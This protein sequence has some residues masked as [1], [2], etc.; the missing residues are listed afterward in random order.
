MS[1]MKNA[2]LAA[3]P[4]RFPT[5]RLVL[6]ILIVILAVLTS[7]SGAQETDPHP[8][9]LPGTMYSLGRFTD[10]GVVLSDFTHTA[11]RFRMPIGNDGNEDLGEDL[12]LLQI[13]VWPESGYPKISFNRE[14]P[15]NAW[16]V[17]AAFNQNR[18]LNNGWAEPSP[19]PASVYR[20]GSFHPG[21]DWNRLGG[22]DRGLP[23]HAVGD[24]IVLLSQA[25][26]CVAA[27]DGEWRPCVFGNMV[28]VGHLIPEGEIMGSV[29]AHLEEP[30]PFAA[31][32]HVRMGDVLGR[33]GAS[34]ATSPHL[35]FE[36]TRP[37]GELIRVDPFGSVQLPVLETASMRIGWHWPIRD[38]E[39]VAR[40]YL[41]PS[42][43]LQ[44]NR[45]FDDSAIR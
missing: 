7:A 21:E 31:G 26:A 6:P 15:E 27:Q 23:V 3:A 41:H 28:V 1:A 24:G 9:T 39:Y 8:L 34:G 45:G 38:P 37:D 35:H 25:Q 17:A 32:D 36:L 16:Y 42:R 12:D 29:Y 18:W 11:R 20:R 44:E 14:S 2:P 19:L 22:E 30:S 5:D 43:F 10:T 33:I 13:E 4:G 40:H